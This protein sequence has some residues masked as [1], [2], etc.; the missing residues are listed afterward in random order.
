[1][2]DS[3]QRFR[4]HIRDR[5]VELSNKVTLRT[6]ENDW[7]T[8]LVYDPPQRFDATSKVRLLIDSHLL[9]RFGFDS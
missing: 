6:V 4:R 3:L 1:M 8:N 7:C 9:R 2:Y 5:L